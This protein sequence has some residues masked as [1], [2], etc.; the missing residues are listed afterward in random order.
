MIEGIIVLVAI[1]LFIL[2]FYYLYT[3]LP[4]TDCAKY[5]SKTSLPSCATGDQ[6]YG[7]ICYTDNWTANG[8]TKTSLC[9]VSYPGDGSVYLNCEG[10]INTISIGQSC[11]ALSD[12][13]RGPG[14]Y[15]SSLCTCQKGG[16][17]ITPPGG[18]YCEGSKLPLICPSDT[19]FFEGVCYSA[20]CPQGTRRSEICTC[21]P[22]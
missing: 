14:W 20:P 1:V 9:G 16:T 10:T 5:A 17:I 4:T 8:G 11:S 12:W 2:L 13:T 6:E 22:V 15:K 18:Y 3:R 7:G 19:D 21:E